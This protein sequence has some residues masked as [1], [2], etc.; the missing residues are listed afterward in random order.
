MTAF[1][2]CQMN[3]SVHS[4]VISCGMPL[5]LIMEPW[6]APGLWLLIE[7]S[8]QVLQTLPTNAQ[9]SCTWQWLFVEWLQLIARGHNLQN[10]MYWILAC[11][12]VIFQ[13]TLNGKM[14]PNE[15]LGTLDASVACCK[16]LSQH[17]LAKKRSWKSAVSS[18]SEDWVSN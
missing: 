6:L 7:T 9:P 2:T 5:V 8:R 15:K 1:C 14:I 3:E 16:V 11:I 4:F 12:P 17:L 10:Y 18:W 13:F